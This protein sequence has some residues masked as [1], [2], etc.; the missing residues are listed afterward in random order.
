MTYQA[1]LSEEKGT[2][3]DITLLGG[4][5]ANR[6]GEQ[7]TFPL[8]ISRL[9]A[10]LALHVQRVTRSRAAGALWTDH[11]Q[12]RADASLRS[13]L[14]RLRSTAPRLVIADSHFIGLSPKVS[15]DLASAKRFAE[16]L[17]VGGLSH[18]E[19]ATAAKYFSMELLP[20]WSD[21]W[22]VLARERHRQRSLH[23]LE[24]IVK[25]LTRDA[26]YARAIDLALIAIELDPFRESAHRALIEVHLAEGN[27]SEAI[28]CHDQYR[29]L[30]GSELGIAP[31]PLLDET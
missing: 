6:S 9:L 28:R 1:E 4:F 23:A 29:E 22:A 15:V 19:E 16:R 7:L 2:S 31:S 25:N 5:S 27:Y 20:D 12:Q 26:Q 24:S 18:R 30:I 14:W 17:E 10:F 11:S 3:W 21:D 13:T 8:G